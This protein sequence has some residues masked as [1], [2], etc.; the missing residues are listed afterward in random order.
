[1]KALVIGGG[2]FLGTRLVEMLLEEGHGVRVLGP[3][4]YPHLEK[5]NVACVLADLADENLLRQSMAGM[6]TVFHVAAKAGYWGSLSEYRRINVDG[7]RRVLS[8]MKAQGVSKLIFTS[9]PSVVGFDRNLANAGMDVPYPARHQSP[10]SQTKAEAEKLVCEANGPQLATVALRPH[11]IFGPK[12]RHVF[13]RYIKR[14]ATG[15]LLRIGTG[16]NRVDFT[17][18]D[19]AAGAHVDAAK[20]LVSHQSP[21]AGHAYFISNGEPVVFYD[22]LQTVITRL[23]FAPIHK[24]LPLAL[25]RF[26]GG[27]LSLTYHFLPLKGEPPVT[28]YLANMLANDHWYDMGP[29]Q[30]DLGYKV[31]VPMAEATERTLAW[32]RQERYWKK[33]ST[34]RMGLQGS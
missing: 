12:D 26:I 25:T 27:F 11:L 15:T 4:H 8:A 14:A 3:H 31:R 16:H 18:V 29:A 21:C 7:T 13:P 19:N 2:G 17:Y 5:K 1:M 6:D 28:P 32:L 9:S 34:T 20:A 33:K 22:F 30:R 24:S 23:G 10:Y